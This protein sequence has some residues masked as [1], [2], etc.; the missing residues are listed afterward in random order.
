MKNKDDIIP[1]LNNLAVVLK[2]QSREK[3][4]ASRSDNAREIQKVLG[5]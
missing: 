4:L 2:R 1:A 3:I 5:E